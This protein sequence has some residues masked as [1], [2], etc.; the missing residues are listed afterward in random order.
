MSDTVIEIYHVL[1]TLHVDA[2]HSENNFVENKLCII[3]QI[4]SLFLTL[5]KKLFFVELYKFSETGVCRNINLN[6][7]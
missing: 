4:K 6:K 3:F 7:E 5:D 2:L 1:I